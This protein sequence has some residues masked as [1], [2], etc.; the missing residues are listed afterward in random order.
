MNAQSF[1]RAVETQMHKNRKGRVYAIA[2]RTGT[3]KG[4]IYP[5]SSVR[6][7][8]R[9]TRADAY[10]DKLNKWLTNRGM[11]PNGKS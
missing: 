3:N 5:Y 11:I 6:Q 10:G 8:A 2:V 1:Y 4:K 9:Q 7:F